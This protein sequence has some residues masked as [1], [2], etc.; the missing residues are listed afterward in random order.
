MLKLELTKEQAEAVLQA[1]AQQPYRNV[2]NLIQAIVK[3]LQEQQKEVTE[4]K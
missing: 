1:L 2:V 4:E 3:Q